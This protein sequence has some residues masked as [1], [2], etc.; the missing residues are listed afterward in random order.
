MTTLKIILDTNKSQAKALLNYLLSLSYD[1][2]SIR[3]ELSDQDFNNETK[4]AIEDA[5]KGKT[6]KYKNS[7]ELFDKLE[8]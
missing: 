7:K 2:N 4:E 1:D 3:V 6:I 8:I 5:R